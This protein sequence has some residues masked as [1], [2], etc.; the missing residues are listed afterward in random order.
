MSGSNGDT[1]RIWKI[2]ADSVRGLGSFHKTL[3]HN[4]FGEV[5]PEAFA[6]LI[7]ATRGDGT[8]FA[9]VPGGPPRTV[10]GSPSSS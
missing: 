9:Q 10:S 5:E 3:P 1:N 2:G 7:S 4:N 6:A 8:E